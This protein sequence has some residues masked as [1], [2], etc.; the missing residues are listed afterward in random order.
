MSAHRCFV[1]LIAMVAAI[2]GG[3]LQAAEDPPGAAAPSKVRVGVYDSRSVALAFGRSQKSKAVVD[4]LLAEAQQAEKAGDLARLEVLKKKGSA[5]QNLRH[6]QVFGN[7]PIHDML[8]HLQPALAEQAR[9]ANLDLIVRDVDIAFQAASVEV[10]DIT[11]GL[12]DACQPTEETLEIIRQMK[13]HPPLP[14]EEF[15]LEHET[16][17]I[18]EPGDAAAAKLKEQLLRRWQLGKTEP[19]DAAAAV[20]D[21]VQAAESWLALVD[22]GKYA[23]SWDHAS[24]HFRAVVPRERWLA[25]MQNL[26]APLGKL[27]SRE[28]TSLAYR[29]KLPDAPPGEYVVIQFQTKFDDNKHVTETATPVREADGAWKADGYYIR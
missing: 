5:R 24:A 19:A 2:A 26:R 3:D 10:V 11:Q 1:A 27:V 23:E 22:A 29:T 28:V 20:S 7:A 13:Q 15:P 21:A 8:P 16:G 12:V 14:L 25:E 6:M 4:Q 18:T 17:D 9:A